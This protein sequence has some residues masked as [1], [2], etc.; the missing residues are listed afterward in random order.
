MSYFGN[1]D[2]DDLL[3]EIEYYLKEHTIEDLMQ[4]VTYAVSNKEHEYISQ[5]E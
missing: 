3:E 5:G 1:K 2:N 4:V